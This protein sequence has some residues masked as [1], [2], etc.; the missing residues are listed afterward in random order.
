[1]SEFEENFTT[2]QPPDGEHSAAPLDA[3]DKLWVAGKLLGVMAAESFNWLLHSSSYGLINTVGQDTFIIDAIGLPAWGWL[4]NVTVSTL[5]NGVLGLAAVGTPVFLFGMLLERHRE[6]FGSPRAF[7]SGALAKIITGLL[8]TLYLFVI[9]TEFAAL[10]LRVQAETATS[11]IPSLSGHSPEFW[12]MLLMSIALILV[13][14]AM[15]M[16][17][18]HIVRASR[19]ALGRAKS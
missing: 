7:F 11:P 12:P 3:A 2:W 6:M 10:Y 4:E 15:G 5:I 19:R 13:N 14:A 16:A 1:M 17:T 8:L 9:V 18:A